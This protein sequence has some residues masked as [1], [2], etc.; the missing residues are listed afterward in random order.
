M[1]WQTAG[2]YIVPGGLYNI[3]FKPFLDLRIHGT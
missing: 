2:D 3:C 1:N